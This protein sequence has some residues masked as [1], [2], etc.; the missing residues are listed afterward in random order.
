M[1]N[2]DSAA[3]IGVIGGSGV[4][5]LDFIENP[6]RHELDTPYG[7]SP[8]ILRGRVKGRKIAFMPRHGRKH[9]NPPHKINFRANLWALKELG[10]KRIIATT[11]V[12][13]L[14]HEIKP[15]EFVLLDQFLDFTKKRPLT[16]YDGDDRR[17]VHIDMTDPYCPELRKIIFDTSKE[18]KIPLHNSGTYVCT[19]GP[20]FETRAEIE[21]FRKLE[22]DVVGMTNVPENVLARELEICYST[23]SI[24][25]NF[26]AGI[27]EEKLTHDEVK[28]IMNKNIDRVQELILSTI[29]DIPKRRTCAC[30]N[31]LEGAKVEP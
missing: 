7:K 27:T 16:F 11:A 26:A 4:Y 19:E 23:I 20:R 24:V 12:G 10:V 28:E 13:S 1:E 14:N 18:M 25:T 29:P 6:Q 5:S 17:V 8:K 22:A 31:A 21:M 15:G 3:E 2:E 30:G 9:S